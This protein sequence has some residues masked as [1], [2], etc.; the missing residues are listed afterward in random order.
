MSDLVLYEVAVGEG[1]LA[2]TSMPGRTGSFAKDLSDI[3]AWRPSFV[4]TLVE[5]SELDDKCAGEI[6]VAF[7]QVGINWAHLPTIDFGTPLIKDNPTWDDMIIFAVR[8]LSDGGRV[9]VH[10]YGGCGRSGMAALRIMIAA[11]EA[12]EPALSRLR[13]IRPCAI[14]TSAQMLWAQK[15]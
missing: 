3:I 11:G 1:V 9:L 4:V 8:Y 12:A 5:Q 6:G 14:E 13:V 7:S 15:L 2:L 10:C